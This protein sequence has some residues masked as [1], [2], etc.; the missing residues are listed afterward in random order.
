[1]KFSSAYAYMISSTI[2]VLAVGAVSAV[3]AVN[4]EKPVA[5]VAFAV[6]ALLGLG[7]GAL[8]IAGMIRMRRR[9]GR[10]PAHASEDEIPSGG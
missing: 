5:R 7:L 10:T 1:M 8:A 9:G 2:F 4:V 3:L 6:A